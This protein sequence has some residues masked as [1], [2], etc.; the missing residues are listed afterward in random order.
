MGSRG[1]T[2][3]DADEAEERRILMI[4]KYSLLIG[5]KINQVKIEA[6]RL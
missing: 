5:V 4:Y 1:E 2:A 6:G 3:G